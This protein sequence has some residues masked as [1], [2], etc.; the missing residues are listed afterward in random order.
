[1]YSHEKSCDAPDTYHE[2]PIVSVGET[3][4]DRLVDE[5]DIC[6]FVPGERIEGHVVDTLHSA[7]T[8][9]SG[10]FS[11]SYPNGDGMNSPSSMNSPIEDEQ[12]GPPFVQKM[13]SSLSGSLLLS[14]K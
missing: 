5:E 6:F 4:T 10:P 2:L 14:K 7:R 12:P 8:L 1:M 3:D 9:A 11:I 13:T